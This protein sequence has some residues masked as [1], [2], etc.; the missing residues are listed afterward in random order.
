MRYTNFDE[1]SQEEIEEPE[2]SI[3]LI[4][5]VPMQVTIELGKCRKTVKEI[6]DF[7]SGTI[8]VLEKLAGEPVEVVVNDKLIARGE[9]IQI[10]D[11]YGVRITEILNKGKPA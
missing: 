5:D 7:N 8:L 11:N 6:L 2:D 1:D 9:V 10:D 3:N 4:I